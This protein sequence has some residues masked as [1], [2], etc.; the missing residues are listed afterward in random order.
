[1]EN[2]RVT[3]RCLCGAVHISIDIAMNDL[4]VCH[5]RNCQRWTG[6]PLFEIEAGSD[7]VIQGQELV[8]AYASSSWAERGFCK[9]CGSHL[10]IKDLRNG[11][12]GIPPGLFKDLPDIRLNRQIFSDHKPA[13]YEF[14]NKTTNI[15]SE[16]I[17]KHFPETKE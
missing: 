10:Y 1:M 4:G 14:S 17:Y 7:V 16:F 13:F 12:Y 11:D 2:K 8:S 5:C 9:Q 6:G 15:T 3:G